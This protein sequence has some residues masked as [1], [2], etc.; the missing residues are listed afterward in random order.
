MSEKPSL[1]ED[2]VVKKIMIE[3]VKSALNLLTEN[4]QMIVKELFYSGT[5]IRTLSENMSVP[6]STLHEQKD[7]IIKKLKKIIDKL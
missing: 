6:K 1:L 3:K 2:T 5:S 7:K 4:E